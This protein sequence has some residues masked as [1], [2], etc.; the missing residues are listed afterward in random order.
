MANLEDIAG[1][2]KEIASQ[3]KEIEVGTSTRGAR[4][5]GAPPS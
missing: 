4:G 3:A 5:S 2:A 1:Q